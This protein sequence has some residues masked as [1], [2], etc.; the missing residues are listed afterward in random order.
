M[1]KIFIAKFMKNKLAVTGLLILGLLASI[2]VFAHYIA[3]YDPTQQDI[4][5][6]LSPPGRTHWMGTDDL[7]RD[8]LSRIL[9]GSR[10]SLTIGLIA[11]FIFVCIGTIVGLIA[12]YYRGWMDA[13]LMRFVDIM[14]CFPVFFL[15]L[16]IIAYIG[17]SIYNIMIILGLVSW[18]GVARLVR[19][20]TI[21]VKERPF[22][23][24]AQGLGLSSSRILFVHILPNVI[25][26]VLV[27]A[28][29][30]VG[31][32]ILT[33][34]GLSFLGLGVQPPTPSWGNMLMAGKDYLYIAWWLSLYPGL[35]IAITVLSFNLIGEGIRDVLDPRL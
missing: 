10:I 27:A 33:E 26:P 35:A 28:T 23:L 21:S 1:L 16:T 19:A 17:P 9:Y 20:E 8:V 31:G 5:Q 12:G 14:L 11:A 6:R 2:A 25:A 7:G 3:P 32:A 30:G 18:T 15:L 29:L 13:L 34:S 22:V 4:L 24:A